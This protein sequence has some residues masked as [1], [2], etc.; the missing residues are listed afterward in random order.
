[1]EYE[2]AFCFIFSQYVRRQLDSQLVGDN[3]I[4]LS[5]SRGS[6]VCHMQMELAATSQSVA[7][8]LAISLSVLSTNIDQALS[9]YGQ[10]LVASTISANVQCDQSNCQNGGE[11]TFSGQPCSCQAG[12]TGDLCQD[13]AQG[14]SNGSIIGIAV[15][16]FGFVLILLTCV[17]CILIKTVRRNQATKL[18]LAEERYNDPSRRDSG[19]FRHEYLYDSEEYDSLEGRRYHVGLALDRLRGTDAQP[20]EEHNFSTPYVVD[21]SE[22]RSPV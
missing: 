18:M 3:C 9:A 6:G 12:F 11:C 1:M 20:Q 16:V 19:F 15:S 4:V 7:D 8:G 21:G 2:V 5:F 17:S 22:R 13:A 14:L 10:T